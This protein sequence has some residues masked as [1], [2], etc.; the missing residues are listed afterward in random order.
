MGRG[1]SV[2]DK[3]ADIFGQ[4]EPGSIAGIKVLVLASGQGHYGNWVRE[5]AT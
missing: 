1:F 4:T 5:K 3:V 2:R